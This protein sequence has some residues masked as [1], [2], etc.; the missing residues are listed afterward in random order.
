[1]TAENAESIQR[2]RSL[3]VKANQIEFGLKL[4]GRVALQCLR[5]FSAFSAVNTKPVLP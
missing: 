3:A 4:R 5:V 2:S 1:M